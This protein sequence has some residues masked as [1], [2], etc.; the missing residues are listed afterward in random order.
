MEGDPDLHPQGGFH[1][2]KGLLDL[3]N[4]ESSL[5][6]LPGYNSNKASRH[7]RWYFE[8]FCKPFFNIN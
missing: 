1:R 5:R 8:D 3:W 6:P 2:G 7:S 4:P